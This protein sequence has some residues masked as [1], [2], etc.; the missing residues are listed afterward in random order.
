MKPTFVVYGNCNAEAFAQF[1][2]DLTP[3]GKSHEIIWARSYGDTRLRLPGAED[4]PLAR[5]EYLWVQNDEENPMIHEGRTPDSCTVLSFPP[6]N[7]TVMWPYLFRDALP[8]GP[9][10]HFPNGDEII[11]ALSEDPDI[12]S[13]NVA[14]A[15]QARIRP[16]HI[17]NAVGHNERVMAKRDAAC[18]VGIADFFWDNFQSIP[19][20]MTYNHP[21]RVFL[22]ALFFRLLDRTLPHLTA[23]ARARAAAWPA[24]YEPFDNLETPV[25]PLVAERLRLEWWRP[26]HKYMFWGERLTFAEYTVR[27]LE[28]RR[29]R[30]AHAAL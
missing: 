26:D 30:M 13:E 28:D 19:M 20:Q 27:Y 17:D 5:C 9:E 12:T 24:N 10:G 22:Q 14:E 21:R 11:Q 29:R 16:E 7:A 15:Y 3:L 6:C 8:V 2:R 4:D 18:D 25:A 1:L 23:A